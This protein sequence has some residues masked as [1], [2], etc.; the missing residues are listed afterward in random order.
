MSE[1]LYFGLL[2]L[3]ATLAQAQT[4][5]QSSVLSK[6]LLGAQVGFLG[7]NAYYEG[8]IANQTTIRSGVNFLYIFGVSYGIDGSL[9]HSVLPS[10]SA[11]PRYY[12]NANK[13]ASEG[14][15]TRNN[16]ADYFSLSFNYFPKSLIMGSDVNTTTYSVVS[17]VPNFGMRRNLSRN[18]NFEFRL[19]LGFATENFENFAPV[20]NIGLKLG[21][22]FLSKI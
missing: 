1:N 16:A 10:I 20:P 3:I 13:R 21:Y 9:Y 7:G 12:F 14:R 5:T 18:V 8:R 11:E 19:G 6:H 17:I 4:S 15:N 2:L 22:D